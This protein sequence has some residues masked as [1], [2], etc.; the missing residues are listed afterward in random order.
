MISVLICTYNGEK[1]IKKQLES[2]L[3][4]TTKP[5]EVIIR[6]DCSTDNTLKICNDFIKDHN[7]DWEVVVN[8]KNL[9]YRLNFIIGLKET[10]GQ[11]VFLCDQDDIWKNNKIEIMSRTIKDNP[12]IKALATTMDI[13]DEND[14]VVREKVKHPYRKRNSIRKI[15]EKEFYKFP[16]YLG[17]TMAVTRDIID[18]L[19]VDKADIISHDVFC[20]YYAMK[21]NGLYYLDLALTKR[22]SS[23]SS[24]SQKEKQKQLDEIYAD[25][26]ELRIANNVLKSL[27][28]FKTI[29]NAKDDATD[30]NLNTQIAVLEKR[31]NYLRSKKK[32]DYLKSVLFICKN[33]SIK[34]AAK[35][36]RVVIGSN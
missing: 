10:K 32:T 11:I 3:M 28:L 12:M 6:D 20:N 17:M 31:I 36:L 35:D 23:L 7:L 26:D 19:D 13:I 15:R 14:R 27:E 18:K 5:D 16:A 4:Q 21:E 30:S 2:I 29:N 34:T 33:S 25:N 24:T 22:R 1:Y 9:G 8:E